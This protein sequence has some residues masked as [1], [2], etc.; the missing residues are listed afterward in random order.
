MMDKGILDFFGACGAFACMGSLIFS[1]PAA[2]L[3]VAALAILEVPPH[4]WESALTP[5]ENNDLPTIN[6]DF[7]LVTT[8]YQR[9][10]PDS[11]ENSDLPPKI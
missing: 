11:N 7:P 2:P 10:T 4:G 3:H 1:A 5:S 6:N 8:I 9:L